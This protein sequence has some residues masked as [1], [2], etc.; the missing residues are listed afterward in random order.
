MI[1]TVK[2]E[3]SVEVIINLDNVL[4]C[5]RITLVSIYTDL[6]VGVTTNST[7]SSSTSSIID[8]Y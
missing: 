3:T 5:T 7:S 2:I 1:N 6:I 4:R 8:G